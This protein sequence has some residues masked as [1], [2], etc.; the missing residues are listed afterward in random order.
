MSR[1]KYKKSAKKLKNEKMRAEDLD[2][3]EDRKKNLEW[4]TPSIWY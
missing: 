4:S 3:G 2:L 1:Y